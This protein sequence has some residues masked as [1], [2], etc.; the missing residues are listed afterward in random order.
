M[1]REGFRQRLAHA[2]RAVAPLPVPQQWSYELLHTARPLHAGDVRQEGWSVD[3]P[4]SWVCCRQAEAVGHLWANAANEPREATVLDEL[5]SASQAIAGRVGPCSG[6][7]VSLAGRYCAC[8]ACTEASGPRPSAASA[9]CCHAT[10]RTARTVAGRAQDSHGMGHCAAA[11]CSTCSSVG[12]G[13]PIHSC[14]CAHPRALRRHRCDEKLFTFNL[15]VVA[16]TLP[17]RPQVLSRRWLGRG[18]PRAPRLPGCIAVQSPG[19]RQPC[20]NASQPPVMPS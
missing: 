7:R 15:P 10:A 13:L 1:C 20:H 17:A 11:C 14:A 9:A 3:R 4:W 8:L 12:Q 2:G 19:S 16:Y 18:A 6:L 5:P